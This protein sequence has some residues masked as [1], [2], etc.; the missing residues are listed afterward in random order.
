MQVTH[1]ETEWSDLDGDPVVTETI[2]GLF[3]P[4]G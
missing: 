1:Y 3:I 4:E 2:V